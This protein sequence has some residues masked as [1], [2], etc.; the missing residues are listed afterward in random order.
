[1]KQYKLIYIIAAFIILLAILSACN[2]STPT[3]APSGN[4]TTTTDTNTTTQEPSSTS[5]EPVAT[6]GQADNV[7]ADIPIMP[8]AY[9]L[10]VPNEL[11]VSYKVNAQ[12][13]DVVTFYQEELP[14]N[15]W[16][17]TNNPDSVVGSM[18]QISRSNDAGDRLI[19][20]IQYNS[21]G[22]F[23]VV[24]MYITRAP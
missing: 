10:A 21:V 9:D 12:I 20:S 24:Q 1:M 15:G 3:A 2:K 19:F 5:Q 16:T 18:A 17:V 14:N 8:D 13:K 22:E 6:S 4:Q 11:N 7:P 23:T